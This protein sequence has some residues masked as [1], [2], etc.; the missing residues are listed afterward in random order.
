MNFFRARWLRCRQCSGNVLNVAALG[1]A[2]LL[3]GPPAAVG[4]SVSFTQQSPF[5][6][7][8]IPVVGPGGAVGGVSIDAKGVVARSDVE[9]SGRLRDARLKALARIDSD[10]LAPSRMR[11]VSLRGIQAAID[12]CRRQ[13]RPVTDALQNLAGLQR[14]EYVLVYPERH[15]I[16][17]AGY[18]EGWKVDPQ[19]NIVGD[20][21]GKPVLQLDDL[22]VALRTAKNAATGS[23]ITCSIDPT[24]EGLKRF[25]RLLKSR[26]LASNEATVARLEESLGPQ[27]ITVTGVP[28]G[29]HFARVLVAADYL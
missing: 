21:T 28:A 27:Q 23:G 15:D 12:E 10:L 19:G 2:A 11:K 16:V 26:E 7:G 3:V 24:E 14:V 4:Q 25:Q 6:V 13:K 8:F 17:L 22:I 18:A 1:I 9:G 20:K 29:S 5:V